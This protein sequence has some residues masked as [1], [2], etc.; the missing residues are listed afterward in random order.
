MAAEAGESRSR[1][2][3]AGSS[4]PFWGCGVIHPARPRRTALRVQHVSL[5]QPRRTPAGPGDRT[6]QTARSRYPFFPYSDPFPSFTYPAQLLPIRRKRE[7]PAANQEAAAAPSFASSPPAT[8][9]RVGRRSSDS[10][11]GL[12]APDYFSAR[13]L[14]R[15]PTLLPGL[16]L[17]S[18]GRSLGQVSGSGGWLQ[19]SRLQ[20]ACLAA[21]TGKE[22]WEGYLPCRDREGFLAFQGADPSHLP[23]TCQTPQLNSLSN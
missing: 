22:K 1:S 7:P 15:G 5:R 14:L 2:Q 17:G 6:C 18:C 11:A 21:A 12:P 8:G 4:A 3:G 10:G 9:A 16:V 13:P 19:G 20:G 23:C